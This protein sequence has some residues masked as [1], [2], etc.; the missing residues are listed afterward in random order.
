MVERSAGTLTTAVS[1][2]QTTW[3]ISVKS[4][5]SFVPFL[6][7]T[8]HHKT[9]TRERTSWGNPNYIHVIVEDVD[10]QDFVLNVDSVLGHVET[11]LSYEAAVKGRLGAK[12]RESME[13]EIRDLLANRTW[14]YVSKVPAGRRV[15]KSKWVYAV[16]LKKD[17]TIERLKS[18]FVVCGYSQIKGFGYTDSFLATL[19]Q[20]ACTNW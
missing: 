19:M 3:M 2:C 1:S 11:P 18:R 9:H 7:H 15:T 8:V 16:K 12:W 20:Y 17:G 14:E 5:L 6:F 4:S 13:K 10:G